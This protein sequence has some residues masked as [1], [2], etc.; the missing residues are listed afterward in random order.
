MRDS[1]KYWLRIVFVVMAVL[2]LTGCQQDIYAP[3]RRT[4]VV[5]M[6]A[7][8]TLKPFARMDE[9]EINSVLNTLDK[10]CRIVVY[11]D[12]TAESLDANH[13]H[14][15][16]RGLYRANRAESYGLVLWSHGKGWQGFGVNRD[17]RR[18]SIPDLK[19][20]LRDLP[21]LDFL[22]FDACHMQALEVIYELREF[23]DYIIGSPAEIPGTG[24]PYDRIVPMMYEKDVR[25]ACRHIAETYYSHYENYD[26]CVMCAIETADFCRYA[27]QIAPR[28]MQ[29]C[30]SG[31]E[32]ELF[33]LQH[34]TTYGAA[35]DYM[36][37][38]YDLGSLLARLAPDVPRYEPLFFAATK[39]WTSAN[40]MEIFHQMVDT[41]HS[42]GITL[43]VPS[44][45]YGRG[46]MTQYL[47]VYSRLAWYGYLTDGD[48]SAPVSE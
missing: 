26:G 14:E 24:A 40:P 45:A 21:H 25:T 33:G 13:M 27:E 2:V 11:V 15:T 37:D 19:R 18:L 41:E 28:L 44:A 43:F 17:G 8:N 16:L 32:P 4:V 7:D 42:M 5:Y 9:R 1:K 10:D 6:A 36:P 23:A 48:S 20:V 30:H 39:T 22:L 35:S 46:H 47:D 29:I 3:A 34:Y 38:L 12:T 31:Q